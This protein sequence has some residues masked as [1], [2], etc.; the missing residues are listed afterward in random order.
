MGVERDH[1]IV[2]GGPKRVIVSP[3]V[4]QPSNRRTEK[5]I[6]QTTSLMLTPPTGIMMVKIRTLKVMKN[7]GNGAMY[8]F[9]IF[10]SCMII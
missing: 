8:N 6:T 2:K 1:T 9:P 4:A 3:K 10:F 5:I 7:V